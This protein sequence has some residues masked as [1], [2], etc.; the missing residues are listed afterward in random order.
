M[1]E[2]AV[3]PGIAVPAAGECIVPG[4]AAFDA[5]CDGTGMLQHGHYIVPNRHHGYC[6]DDNVRALMLVN[7]V[8]WKA[9][10]EELCR[11]STF[12]SFIQYAWN[13]DARRFR[14]FM[15]YDRTWCEDVG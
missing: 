13:P 15:N 14:N 10:S 5:L 3:A 1:L 4:L 6:L 2:T 9:P 12:A 11:A 8:Q 7:R